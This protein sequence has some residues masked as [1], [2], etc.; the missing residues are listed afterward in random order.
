MKEGF[1]PYYK[2]CRMVSLLLKFNDMD[3][4]LQLMIVCVPKN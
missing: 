1:R 4:K 3:L 2:K